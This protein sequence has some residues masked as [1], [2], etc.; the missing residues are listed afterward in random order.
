M[1]Q[2]AQRLRQES[3]H[4][5]SSRSSQA[6]CWEGDQE[7]AASLEPQA[8]S[9]A[10]PLG[11]LLAAATSLHHHIWH[12]CLDHIALMVEVEERKRPSGSGDTAGSTRRPGIISFE[13]AEDGRMEGSSNARAA[14]QMGWALPAAVIQLIPLRLQDPVP[15]SQ[16]LEVHVVVPSAAQRSGRFTGG[17]PPPGPAY[18]RL[19]SSHLQ[20]QKGP[21]VSR[22][23]QEAPPRGSNHCAVVVFR[24]SAVQL[25]LQDAGSFTP[26]ATRGQSQGL[27]AWE[28]HLVLSQEGAGSPMPPPWGP[29]E[30]LQV[31]SARQGGE[32]VQ[33]EA[34][35]VKVVGSRRGQVEGEHGAARCS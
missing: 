9:L 18:P 13:K 24:G 21:L 1:Y 26:Q 29:S 23:I 22:G 17:S 8:K 6:A 28:S 32:N 35:T 3:A 15:P 27:P 16:F 34:G 4:L 33:P 25:E 20:L 14:S 19:P 12:I 30:N 2:P 7:A 31:E 11:L 5:G 10:S